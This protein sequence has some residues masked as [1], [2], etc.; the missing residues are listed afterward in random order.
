M[1]TNRPEML[2]VHY[3]VPS[4]GAVLNSINTRLDST[5]V[6]WILKH[7]E[8]KLLLCDPTSAGIAKQAAEKIGI[9]IQVFSENAEV[10]FNILTGTE[11]QLGDLSGSTKDE[12][13]SIALNYTSG[14][15][16]D[17]KGVVLHHRKAYLNFLGNVLA[18]GCGKLT[19]YL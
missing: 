1:A 5:T 3:A 19:K 11:I 6:A 18:L 17:P 9:P 7:T 10:G 14:T 2:A 4:L 15:T 13:A 8:S 16:D 12:W